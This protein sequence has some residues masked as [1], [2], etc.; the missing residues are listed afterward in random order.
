MCDRGESILCRQH[1]L[2]VAC[3]VAADPVVLHMCVDYDDVRQW[4]NIALN[5]YNKYTRESSAHHCLFR[6]SREMRSRQTTAA[7]T[8]HEVRIACD[9]AGFSTTDAMTILKPHKKEKCSA[10]EEQ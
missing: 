7:Q 10:S 2:A 8:E 1:L 5:Q 6:T 9:V 4:W 3:E